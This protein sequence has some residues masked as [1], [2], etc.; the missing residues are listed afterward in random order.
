MEHKKEVYTKDNGAYV[1]V[2]T[3]KTTPEDGW[4]SDHLQEVSPLRRKKQFY[5]GYSVKKSITTDDPSLVKPFLL[6]IYSLFF[7]VGLLIF[8][9]G[10]R[11]FGGVFLGFTLV[12]FLMTLRQ[13]KIAEDRLKKRREASASIT[14][15]EDGAL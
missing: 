12:M 4:V 11:T 15:E 8:R 2:E 13:I 9:A 10:N 6:G 5:W 1:E 3:V 7:I 14:D